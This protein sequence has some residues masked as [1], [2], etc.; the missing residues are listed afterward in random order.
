MKL[1]SYKP[2]YS[3]TTITICR[4][5]TPF[6]IS[7]TIENIKFVHIGKCSETSVLYYLNANGIDIEEYHRKQPPNLSQF[8]YFIWIRN[9]IKRFI[10]AFNHSKTIID[11]DIQRLKQNE[12]LTLNNC[13]VPSKIERKINTGHAFNP[14]YDKLVSN[15]YS[16]N[17][18]AESLTSKNLSLKSLALD[19]IHNKEKIIQIGT[20]ENFSNDLEELCNKLSIEFKPKSI[21]WTRKAPQKYSTEL[22]D[23][24]VKNLNKFYKNNFKYIKKNEVSQTHK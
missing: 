14:A 6:K 7:K 9:P 19:L 12:I 16:A 13:L 2:E 18:L 8:C 17:E 22:S 1:T 20:T 21:T 23:L 11:F 4:Q 10:S 5:N 24:A 3:D 15:F